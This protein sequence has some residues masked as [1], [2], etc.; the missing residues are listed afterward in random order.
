MEESN[1]SY[2]AHQ[3]CL[4]FPD[5]NDLEMDALVAD[6]KAHGLIHPI[7]L[8]D[9]KGREPSRI[10]DGRHRLE[11]CRRADIEP[12]FVVY[13]GSD[14]KAHTVSLN[15]HRRNL[16]PTERLNIYED[17]YPQAFEKNPVGRPEKKNLIIDQVSIPAIASATGVGEATVRRRKDAKELPAPLYEKVREGVISNDAGAWLADQD[18]DHVADAT[19]DLLAGVKPTVAVARAKNRSVSSQPPPSVPD[20][21]FAVVYADPPW[22]MV[23]GKMNP[24]YGQGAHGYSTENDDAIR[25]WALEHAA[26]A[27][28]NAYLFLWAV[29]PRLPFA[30]DVVA[31][32]GFEYVTNVVWWKSPRRRTV[33]RVTRIQHEHLLVGAK[34]NPPSASKVAGSAAFASVFDLPRQRHSVKPAGIRDALDALLDQLDMHPRVA[35]HQRDEWSGWKCVGREIK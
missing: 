12:T 11:A 20:G 22:S 16:T 25:K 26:V 13:E 9:D 8:W 14:P 23:A 2:P 31:M 3:F 10:L 19:P 32:L 6:I 29:A 28:D 17:L 21:K 18:A 30:L 24:E 35:F 5:L 4:A 15:M 33:S 27:A 1:E 7:V 34:G